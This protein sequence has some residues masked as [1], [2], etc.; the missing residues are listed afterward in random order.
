MAHHR[1]TLSTT[2]AAGSM[3][4]NSRLVI[5]LLLSHVVNR[6]RTRVLFGILRIECAAVEEGHLL[7]V[8]RLRSH[9][10]FLHRFYVQILTEDAADDSVI[11]GRGFHHP[12]ATEL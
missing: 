11:V 5:Q 7:H 10:N 4:E 1:R 9:A 12:P 3:K 8:L 6:E 2:P